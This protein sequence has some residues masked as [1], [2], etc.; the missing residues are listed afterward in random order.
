MTRTK[1]AEE[2]APRRHRAETA[3]SDLHFL[4]SLFAELTGETPHS[5][6]S[7][8]PAAACPDRLQFVRTPPKCLK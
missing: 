4:R 2:E 5:S 6:A 7:R 3:A 1:P 8:S